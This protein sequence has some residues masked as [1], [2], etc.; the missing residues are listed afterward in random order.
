MP[1]DSKPNNGQQNM[2]KDDMKDQEYQESTKKSD[3]KSGFF[4]HEFRVIITMS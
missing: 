1:L 3:I 2:P 4:E